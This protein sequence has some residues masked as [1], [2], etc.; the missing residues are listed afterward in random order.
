[1]R[2]KYVESFMTAIPRAMHKL[3]YATLV[4]HNIVALTLI[5]KLHL[6]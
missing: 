2:K 6:L 5:L 4:N 1:M 3:Q